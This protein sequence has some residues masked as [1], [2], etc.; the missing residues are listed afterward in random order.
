MVQLSLLN[1]ANL[2]EFSVLAVSEPYSWRNDKDNSVVIPVRHHNWIK[3]IPTVLHDGMFPIRSM[4]WIR[5]DLETRQIPV[6][7]ADITLALLHLPDRS[8]LIFSLYVPK[9]NLAAL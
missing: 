1:D 3:M 6:D 7:S 5:K 8:I 4:L 2:A 9:S